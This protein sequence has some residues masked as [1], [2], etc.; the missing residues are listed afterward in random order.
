M[1]LPECIA[2]H[3]VILLRANSTMMTILKPTNLHQWQIAVGGA[4][5]I[6]RNLY[7]NTEP[8]Y[9]YCLVVNRDPRV[10]PPPLQFNVIASMLAQTV[11]FGDVV[12][13]HVSY[14]QTCMVVGSPDIEQ[15]KR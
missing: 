10:L 15:H 5:K 6:V 8:Y 14:L 7:H 11:I 9:T 13:T 3:Q 2:D 12:L 4:I 1:A